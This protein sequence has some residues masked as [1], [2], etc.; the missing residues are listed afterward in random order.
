MFEMFFF[1]VWEVSPL[2]KLV[3]LKKYKLSGQLEHI[4]YAKNTKLH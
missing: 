1:Q 3:D 2:I 4:K